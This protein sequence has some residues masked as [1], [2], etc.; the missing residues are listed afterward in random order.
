MPGLKLRHPDG[1][2][3]RGVAE[4]GES[5]GLVLDADRAKSAECGWFDDEPAGGGADIIERLPTWLAGGIVAGFAAVF[6]IGVLTIVGW[7]I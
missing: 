5:A 3:T 4:F 7:L 6:W 1:H 2:A